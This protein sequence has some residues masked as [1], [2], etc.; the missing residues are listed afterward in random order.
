MVISRTP[1][2]LLA[3][4]LGLT[5]AAPAHALPIWQVTNADVYLEGEGRADEY[6]NN[7]APPALP[8]VVLDSALRNTLIAGF[9]GLSYGNRYGF[10]AKDRSFVFGRE[11]EV[12]ASSK[13][14]ATIAGDG[15][16]EVTINWFINS[17][18]NSAALDG[19]DAQSF[20]T[21]EDPNT[22]DN[23]FIELNTTGVPAGT[24]LII[25]YSWDAFSRGYNPMEP[26]GLVFP[27]LPAPPDYATISGTSLQI[28]GA[29]QLNP[30]FSFDVTPPFRDIEYSLKNQ[31]GT[32]T[33]IAGTIVRIDVSGLVE[34]GIYQRG[35]GFTQMKDL[36]WGMFQGKI[37]LST[38]TPP[39]P[40]PPGPTIPPGPGNPN[41]N[42]T[43]DFSVDIGGDTERSAMPIDSD[44]VFDPGDVYEWRTPLIPFPG[45]N[46]YRND[47]TAFLGIDPP[48]VPAAFGP[49]VA[50]VC[51]GLPLGQVASQ[52]FDLD[53]HDA[54]EFS[55]AQAFQFGVR[56]PFNYFPSACINSA[57]YLL[58][59]FE[60]DRANPYTACDVPNM[61]ASPDGYT[62]GQTAARDEVVGLN[63]DLLPPVSILNQYPLANEAQVHVSLGPNPIAGAEPDDDDVDSLDAPNDVLVCGY[64]YFSA[65]HE[66]TYFDPI[67]GVS[68]Q[69]GAI[70][71][72]VPGGAP[73]K[74]IDPALHLG[75]PATVDLADFEFAW[76][77]N[78]QAPGN[79]VQLALIFAVHPDDPTTNLDESGGLNPERLYYS[80]LT[81][82]SAPLF[83]G[84]LDD[85]ID[86]VTS[87]TQDLSSLSF[88]PAL[89]PGDANG[90]RVVNFADITSVL[91]NF[92]NAYPAGT[93]NGPGDANHDGVVNFAD[94]TAVLAGFGRVCP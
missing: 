36:A 68:L 29:E 93:V 20:A 33:I 72:V 50:P 31:S 77:A 1:L 79:P 15:T 69:P 57:A 90:D 75:L 87:V 59:S 76:L 89:C 6:I 23:F 19:Y 62:Y 74:V 3:V 18:A 40:I 46:G 85:P 21:L 88:V 44:E 38:G 35:K 73:I 32:L 22:G 83:P 25:H 39:I 49:P 9:Q 55:L 10:D 84:T 30:F 47:A 14:L 81:G 63:L 5:L 16:Q 61:L 45:A 66:A 48:P 60:D 80:Y 64:R 2:V 82:S 12:T 92:G 65:D 78:A 52:F 34:S 67:N 28:N 4:G 70:Y 51:S 71:E 8:I 37:R 24:P 56:L 7:P 17:R 42:S 54:L 41:P 94:I 26:P 11:S 27:G 53:G 91:A 86:A 13:A 43:I 58:I